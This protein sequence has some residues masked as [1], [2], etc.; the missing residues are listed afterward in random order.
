MTTPLDLSTYLLKSPTSNFYFQDDHDITVGITVTYQALLGADKEY[1]SCCAGR[2]VSERS[3]ELRV[4][5]AR[6]LWHEL[7]TA[8]WRKANNK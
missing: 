5:D 8:G 1:I 7:V 4:E 2:I 6:K 3:F